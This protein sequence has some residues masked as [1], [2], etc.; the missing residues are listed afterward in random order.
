M[1]VKNLLFNSSQ[2]SNIKS[3]IC[4]NA[5]FKY[6]WNTDVKTL[7]LKL[8]NAKNVK[9]RQTAK[10]MWI[11]ETP[12]LP[13]TFN[14]SNYWSRR[15]PITRTA[16]LRL[17]TY[18]VVC[19]L[20]YAGQRLI[21]SSLCLVLGTAIMLSL[22]VLL[23][24]DWLVAVT[25]A[26]EEKWTCRLCRAVDEQTGLVLRGIDSVNGSQRTTHEQWTLTWTRSPSTVPRGQQNTI[27]ACYTLL[28][29][30]GHNNMT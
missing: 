8:G 18:R 30:T 3:K 6:G 15:I 19:C 2:G 26:K 9:N 17:V 12:K 10:S 29:H 22:L 25:W 27:T 14:S 1:F 21:A 11:V 5:V 28:R 13:S 16:S 20:L 7:M 23:A 24:T 4:L